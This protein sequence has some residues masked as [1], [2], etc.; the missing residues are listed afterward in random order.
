MLG[1]GVLFTFD[2]MHYAKQ[3]INNLFKTHFSKILMESFLIK[4]FMH[5]V[6]LKM[7]FP[8]KSK[9]IFC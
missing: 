6:T 8:N 7:L 2:Y 9:I 1:H 4:I 3:I 5:R